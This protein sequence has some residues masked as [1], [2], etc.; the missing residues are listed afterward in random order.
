[1]T[2][3]L[4]PPAPVFLFAEPRVV[5]LLAL[6]ECPPVPHVCALCK[7]DSSLPLPFASDDAPDGRPVS[8]LP[9]P[10]KVGGWSNKV[11]T[12]SENNRSTTYRWFRWVLRFIL[13]G[14]RCDIESEE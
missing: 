4:A 14:I 13:W 11:S 10:L 12:I 5:G 1:M 7:V 9:E 3:T 6:S 8:V 2:G